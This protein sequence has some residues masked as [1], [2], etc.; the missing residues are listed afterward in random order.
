M[1]L[2][3]KLAAASI[4]ALVLAATTAAGSGFAAAACSG[5]P[6]VVIVHEASGVTK[7]LRCYYLPTVSNGRVTGLEGHTGWITSQNQPSRYR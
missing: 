7:T 5:P 2:K 6:N 1:S 4:G 3:S